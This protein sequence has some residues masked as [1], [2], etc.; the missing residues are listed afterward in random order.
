MIRTGFALVSLAFIALVVA[1]CRRHDEHAVPASGPAAPTTAAS[2]TS[3]TEK[4]PEDKTATTQPADGA[5]ADGSTTD[6]VVSM[7]ED[8]KIEGLI[9][10][11]AD[12]KDATFIRNGEG[13]NTKEAIEHMR[14]KWKWKSAEIKTAD[15]FIRIAATGSSMSGKPYV[16]RF[17]DGREVNSATWFRERL[18]EIERESE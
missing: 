10:A 1:G 5:S 16:I 18:R 17:A 13:H 7:S 9:A 6:R 4:I 12:L 8:E 14:R 3:P 11:L 2:I 15:D